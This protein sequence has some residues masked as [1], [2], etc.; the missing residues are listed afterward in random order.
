MNNYFASLYNLDFNEDEQTLYVFDSNYISYAIQS[1]HNSEKFFNALEKVIDKTYLPFIVYLESIDN[2][3]SHISGTKNTLDAINSIFEG[4]E[5]LESVFDTDTKAFQDFLKK[6]IINNQ[7]IDINALIGNINFKGE[8]GANK[9][10]DSFLNEIFNKVKSQ[11]DELNEVLVESLKQTEPDKGD[12]NSQKYIEG[13]EERLQRINSIF[14][15]EGVLGKE[16]TQDKLD[17]FEKVIPDRYQKDIPPGFKDKHKQK[18]RKFAT[19]EFKASFGDAMLWLDI[20]EFVKEKKF[21]NVVI[22][23]DDKKTDWCTSNGASELELLPELKVEFLKETGIPVIRKSSSLFIKDILSL[24]EDEKKGIEKEIDEIEKI[25]S[26]IEYQNT[27]IVR[28]R[29]S[30]FE[31]VFIGENSWYSVRINEDR[32]PFLKYIAVY[33]KTPIKKITHYAEIED[34]IISP[35]DSSKKKIVF[36]GEA[37][38]LPKKIPLGNDW[39]ALQSNRY[40]NF[41]NLFTSANTDELFSKTFENDEE[42]RSYQIKEFDDGFETKQ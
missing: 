4:I 34:I 13:I 26:E 39:T 24:S 20:I 19:L 30:G 42:E 3:R 12:F 38:E 8:N 1:V 5:D 36:K 35:E 7:G 29:K 21:S 18:M 23:S 32:I 11:L 37:K 15:K 25:K 41:D 33:Q 28:A 16:Y 40:T 10:I 9:K 14:L 2:I 17:Y 31:E 6:K 22:V 27:I